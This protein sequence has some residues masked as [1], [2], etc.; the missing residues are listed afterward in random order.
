VA[1]LRLLSPRLSDGTLDFRG[2]MTSP[3]QNTYAINNLADGDF[4]SISGDLRAPSVYDFGAGF[5]M[6]ADAF[7]LQARWNFANRSQGA[8]VYGSNDGTTWTLLT[9]RETTNTTDAGFAMETIPVRDEVKNLSFR[10][11]KVQR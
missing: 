1:G 3:T 11:L 6:R 7:G 9:S 10:F 4:N 5:R 8:N 2:I